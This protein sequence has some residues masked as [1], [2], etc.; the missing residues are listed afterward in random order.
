MDPSAWLGERVRMRRLLGSSTGDGR[1]FRLAFCSRCQPQSQL[2][3]S[4]CQCQ[5]YFSI[6]NGKGAC[7]HSLRFC[8][9]E[10]KDL[11][12]YAPEAGAL[13]ESSSVVCLYPADATCCLCL[14][15]C[16]QLQLI[17]SCRTVAAPQ[18]IRHQCK[19][20]VCCNWLI[21]LNLVWVLRQSMNIS[22]QQE[23]TDTF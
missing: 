3:V 12:S 1:L 8:F 10:L 16:L 11:G 9:S 20:R 5:K 23:L 22:R 15:R 21:G 14:Q 6:G 18:T 17:L 7:M 2:S 19:T 13:Q 4:A